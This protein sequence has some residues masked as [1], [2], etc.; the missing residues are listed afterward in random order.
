MSQQTDGFAKIG[1]NR[2]Q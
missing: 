1:I 2:E